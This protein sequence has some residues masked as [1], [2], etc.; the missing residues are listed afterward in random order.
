MTIS[1]ALE[2]SVAYRVLHALLDVITPGYDAIEQNEFTA[3]LLMDLRKALDTA[4]HRILLHK[5]LHYGI[6]GPAYTLIESYLSDRQQFVSI[7]NVKSSPKPI[8]R[9]IGVPQGSILGPLLLY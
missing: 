9:P 5:L 4:S 6:R 3:L 1:T 8:S 2:K 7:N